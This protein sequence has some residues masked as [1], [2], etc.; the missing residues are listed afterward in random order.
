MLLASPA[1][2]TNFTRNIIQTTFQKLEKAHTDLEKSQRVAIIEK[3][4]SQ[5]QF[6]DTFYR[7]VNPQKISFL[8]SSL[9]D[10][11]LK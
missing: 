5:G 1:K 2:Y 7:A 6:P 4:K 10:I 8:N 9:G 3:S 11:V